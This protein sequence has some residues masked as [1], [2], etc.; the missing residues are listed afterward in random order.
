MAAIK[1]ELPWPENDKENPERQS[2]RAMCPAPIT[3]T[4][5]P[6]VVST[7][8]LA[9]PQP[10]TQSRYT[11][12]LPAVTFEPIRQKTPHTQSQ[13]PILGQAYTQPQVH[14]QPRIQDITAWKGLQA[15]F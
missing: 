10:R 5:T 13:A 3:Q 12:N 2:R 7:P 6:I 11:P 1:E 4:P 9:Q 8:V 15:E 14:T